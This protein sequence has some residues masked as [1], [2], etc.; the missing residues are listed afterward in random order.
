MSVLAISVWY[1]GVGAGRVAWRLAQAAHEPI[2]VWPPL[3]LV[4]L[5]W[6]VDMLYDWVASAVAE[7]R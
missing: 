2:P 1:L 7:P 3:W 4:G 5:A 6:P